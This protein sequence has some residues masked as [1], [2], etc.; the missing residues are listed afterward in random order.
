MTTALPKLYLVRHGDTA[1]EKDPDL[2]EWNYGSFQGTRTDDILKDKPDW[3]HFRRGYPRGKSPRE[4]AIRAD[5]FI[6]KLHS[7]V[8]DALATFTSQ[9]IR[10]IGLAGTIWPQLWGERSIFV[11]PAWAC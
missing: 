10:M 5:R 11:A 7:I 4:F 9:I 1:A 2:T 8:G 3:K 6:A